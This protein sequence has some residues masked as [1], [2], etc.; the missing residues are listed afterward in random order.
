MRHA[1]LCMPVL[2][3]GQGCSDKVHGLLTRKT[4][5]DCLFKIRIGRLVHGNSLWRVS[6][7]QPLQMNGDESSRTRYDWK[8]N[9]MHPSMTWCGAWYLTSACLALP[10]TT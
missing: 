3:F 9:M 1:N 10:E 8:D 6:A 2:H 5:S 7:T 4:L